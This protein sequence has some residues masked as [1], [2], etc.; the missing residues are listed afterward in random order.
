MLIVAVAAA[1][2]LVMRIEPDWV[3][4]LVGGLPMQVALVI[5]LFRMIR[6]RLRHENLSP[7]LVGFEVG[8]WISHTAFAVVG[9]AAPQWLDSHLSQ[10]LN[11]LTPR[12]GA[13]MF[14]PI[15]SLLQAV[16]LVTFYLNGLQL[17]L[18]L[19]AG[20]IMQRSSKRTLIPLRTSPHESRIDA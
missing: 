2:Y 5:G 19:V 3:L 4:F 20:W 8:G 11:M 14:S 7:F 1:D 13:V 10:M 18:A 16:I 17:G 6:A 9:V 12:L 15:A